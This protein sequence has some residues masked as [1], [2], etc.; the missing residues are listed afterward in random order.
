MDEDEYLLYRISERFSVV[1]KSM[2]EA[3]QKDKVPPEQPDMLSE[4]TENMETFLALRKNRNRRKSHGYYMQ[5]TG[6]V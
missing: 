5:Q 3:H 6:R 1:M 2:F 4:T